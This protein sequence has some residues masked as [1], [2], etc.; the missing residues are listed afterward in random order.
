[1][2]HHQM[3]GVPHQM[4]LQWYSIHHITV[5]GKQEFISLSMDTSVSYTFEERLH[6]A[7]T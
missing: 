4:N 1:M 6:N 5:P 7:L 3:Y 2:T